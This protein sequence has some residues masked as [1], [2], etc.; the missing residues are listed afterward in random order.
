MWN[1]KAESVTIASVFSYWYIWI[2]S[3][4]QQLNEQGNVVHYTDTH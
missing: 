4:K 3:E 1:A 2:K